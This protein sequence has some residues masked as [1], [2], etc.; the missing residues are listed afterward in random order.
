MH[1]RLATYRY[2][3]DA[4]QLAKEAE[5]GMLPIFRD[6]PGFRA[7]SLA[8]SDGEILSLSVWDTREQIDA[9]NSAAASWIRENLGDSLELNNVRSGELLL[10]T[11]LGV[12]P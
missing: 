11:T 5:D 9:A 7:Y 6:Q 1:T 4:R 8:E 2:Q 3:G 12:T 10:S